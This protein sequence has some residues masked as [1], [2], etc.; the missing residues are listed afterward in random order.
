ML[1][2]AGG[3]KMNLWAMFT[4]GLLHMDTSVLSTQHKLTFINFVLQL[5]AI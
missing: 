4:Y 3:V 1:G 5:G 2:T